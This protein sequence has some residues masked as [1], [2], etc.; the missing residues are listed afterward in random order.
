MLVRARDQR[1]GDTLIEV[2]FAITIFS[3]VLVG[4]LSIMNQ[5]MSTSQRALEITVVRQEIDAQAEVLRFLHT[6]YIAVYQSGNAVNDYKS[7]T[8]AREWAT[9]VAKI[10]ADNLPKVTD[11]NDDSTSCPTTQPSSSFIMNSRKAQFIPVVSAINFA[12]ASTYSKVQYNSADSLSSAQ[13]IWIEAIS[14]TPSLSDTNQ[15]NAGY[16]DF[17]IRACWDSPGQAVPIRIGTIVRL[18]EPLG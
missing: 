17:H 9:M 14:W 6:S 1:R 10:K 5:G 16:V 18:Y 12:S 13:G 3:L 15:N 8:P 2:L 11:F 7:D 4:S